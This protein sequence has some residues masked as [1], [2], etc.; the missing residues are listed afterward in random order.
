MQTSGPACICPVVLGH[1]QSD[2]WTCLYL[3]SG[4]GPHAVRP[5]D[6]LVSVQW[7]WATRSQTSGPACICPGPH[8]VRPVDLLVSVLGH[9]QS[10]QWTCLYLSWAT[11][12]QTSGPACIC[13]VV[14]GHMQSGIHYNVQL[15]FM[16]LTGRLGWQINHLASTL[17]CP[18]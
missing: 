12:S 4:P 7:S 13:P 14:L 16:R 18:T 10:D 6:L 1:T 3:S 2:Q 11:C 5:V 17:Q 8:A 15:E 9:T